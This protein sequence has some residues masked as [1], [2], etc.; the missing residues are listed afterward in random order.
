MDWFGLLHL[1]RLDWRSVQQLE[2]IDV[3]I[4]ACGQEN[5]QLREELAWALGERRRAGIHCSREGRST[6]IGPCS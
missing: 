2:A 5:R 6:T 3:V 1:H 4:A